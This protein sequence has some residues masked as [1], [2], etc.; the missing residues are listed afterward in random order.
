MAES[1]NLAYDLSRY[2]T[3]SAA[4]EPR[5]VIKARKTVHPAVG[6]P[7]VIAAIL[8]GG[9]LMC[10][11]LYSRV[12]DS[13]LQNEITAQTKQLELLRS[14]NVRMQS[15]IEG[16]TSL[17]NVE[18]FAEDILGLKKLD[19]SQIEYVQLNTDNVVEIPES[20]TN[21]FVRI[22][23]KFYGLLEYLRG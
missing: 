12:E 4:K 14:E 3:T 8:I 18:D 23:N 21:I 2:E 22:R 11:V 17:K 15:E 5:P 19:K 9:A 20:E 6:L 16:K 13:R 1:T 7:K 10:G